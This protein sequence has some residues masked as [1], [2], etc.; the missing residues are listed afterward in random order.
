[1]QKLLTGYTMYFNK[2]YERNGP[3]FAGVFK[4]K[5]V[6]TDRYFQHL[7]SYVHF[8]PASLV[9]PAWK[10]G[11]AKTKRLEKKLLSYPYSSL[12][13]I[14]GS[15]TRLEK[16]ILSEEIFDVYRFPGLTRMVTEAHAYYQERERHENI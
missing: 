13:D 16:T 6:S 8:N 7:V 14:A 1:M 3:L 4:S 2:R 15:V 10:V 9:D 5:H 11:K 12:M